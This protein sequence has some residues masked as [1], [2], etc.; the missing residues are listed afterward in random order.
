[1]TV[2]ILTPDETLYSGEAVYVGLPGSDGSM[3]IMER[4]AALITTLQSGDV[5]V[6][7]GKGEETFAVKGG[8]VEVLNNVVTVLAA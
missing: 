3:G 6:R 1:M 5:I 7:T 8:T 2:H 4:H